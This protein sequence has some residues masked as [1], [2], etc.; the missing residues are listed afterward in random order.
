VDRRKNLGSRDEILQ[1]FTKR[2]SK[3]TTRAK[4]ELE[5][6]REGERAISEH[7]VEVLSDVLQVTTLAPCPATNPKLPMRKSSSCS[8]SLPMARI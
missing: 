7:L 3:L 6:L 5:R 8:P 4:E 2:M 1:M